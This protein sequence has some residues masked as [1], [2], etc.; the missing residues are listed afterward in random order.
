MNRGKTITYQ[1][2]R[3]GCLMTCFV[4]L[5]HTIAAIWPQPALAQAG[6][7]FDYTAAT[8]SEATRQG[9]VNA[10]G[11][12]WQCRGSRCTVSGPWPQPGV[13][14]CRALAQQVGRI[15]SYG[16]PGASLNATQLAECN[17]GTT[18][19][20][21]RNKDIIAQPPQQKL[22]PIKNKTLTPGTTSG[23]QAETVSNLPQAILQNSRP[24]GQFRTAAQ[25]W[26]CD[27]TRCNIPGLST[28][29]SGG[30]R[31][32]D[33]C[34]RLAQVA[35]RVT[36]FS[37][38][39]EVFDADMLARCNSPWVHSY[40]ILACSGADDLRDASHLTIGINIRGRTFTS[41]SYRRI[42]KMGI[43]RNSCQTEVID[44]PDFRVSEILSI[45]L[46]FQS[47]T[48]A[49]LQTADNWDLA[50]FRIMGNATEPG[51]RSV[52]ITIIDRQ[53]DPA[54]RFESPS[55]WELY[56]YWAR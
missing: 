51:G 54:H 38:G 56:S 49:V 12:P 39:N 29:L 5:V 53:P 23:P 15:K 44:G 52:I 17:N 20:S 26:Y 40:E 21:V 28:P 42:L 24:A 41:G 11:I 48:S 1:V 46:K 6:G 19:P 34:S 2:I 9:T 45:G 22:P 14:A 7:S 30:D 55:F 43:Q 4:I 10:A 50:R 27:G 47:Y 25:T 18:S 3:T 35:G 37:D 13:T 8:Y 32:V 16:H 33:N 31:S 36:W